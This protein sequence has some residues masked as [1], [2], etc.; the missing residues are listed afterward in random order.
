MKR[1]DVKDLI[2]VSLLTVLICQ[3]TK[4]ASA[5]KESIIDA[6]CLISASILCINKIYPPLRNIGIDARIIRKG[7]DAKLVWK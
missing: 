4:A 1:F 7:W 5:D 6:A 2:I 3:P